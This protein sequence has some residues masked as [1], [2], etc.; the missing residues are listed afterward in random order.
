MRFARDGL[1]SLETLCGLLSL[2]PPI[3]DTS[4]GEHQA[5]IAV[6]GMKKAKDSCKHAAKVLCQLAGK[7]FDENMGIIV[8][9]VGTWDTYGFTYQFKI[10]I[11]MSFE[12]GQVLDI[13]VLSKYCNLLQ[14]T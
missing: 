1:H 8:T 13:E 3:I 11:A 6:A 9:Y 7:P 14:T 2:P 12:I 4:Y 10:V 5:L